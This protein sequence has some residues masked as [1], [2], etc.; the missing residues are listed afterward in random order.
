M[1]TL[2]NEELLAQVREKNATI[3]GDR[4]SSVL[5]G[6][7]F[8]LEKGDRVGACALCYYDFDKLRQYDIEPW[9]IEVGLIEREVRHG[10]DLLKIPH[11]EEAKP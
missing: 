10:F 9:L 4:G 6:V 8:Y 1:T 7:I 11:A 5:K 2:S 3:N